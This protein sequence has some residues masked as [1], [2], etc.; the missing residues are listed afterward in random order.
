MANDQNT[1]GIFQQNSSSVRKVWEI[2]IIGRFIEHEEIRIQEQHTQQ[3]QSSFFT[4]TE[5]AQ[6]GI[7]L[8]TGEAKFFHKLT[9]RNFTAI[10]Q[11]E[12]FSHVFYIF[13]RPFVFFVLQTILT[14]ISEYH[15]ITMIDFTTVG[16]FLLQRYFLKKVDLPTPFFPTTPNSFASF[17]S[18]IKSFH[19][20]QVA[21]TLVY[22]FHLRDL[23]TLVGSF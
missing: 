23:A 5:F 20:H 7:L 19:D 12:K 17:E 15:R 22:L 6:H 1:S 14:E 2:K 10:G 18:V 8:F 21:K 11:Q 3:V 16:H 9:G 4:T 13:N